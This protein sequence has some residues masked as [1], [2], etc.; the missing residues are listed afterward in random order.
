MI[1]SIINTN[2]YQSKI[3]QSESRGRNIEESLSTGKRYKDSGSIPGYKAVE[4]RDIVTNLSQ[5]DSELISMKKVLSSLSTCDQKIQ[6]LFNRTAEFKS[7]IPKMTG[8][9]ALKSK[10]FLADLKNIINTQNPDG[11]YLFGGNGAPIKSKDLLNEAVLDDKGNRI[12][13]VFDGSTASIDID[14]QTCEMANI[15]EVVNELVSAVHYHGGRYSD[16]SGWKNIPDLDLEANIKDSKRIQDALDKLNESC[17]RKIVET[18]E[19][20]ETRI[21]QLEER[22][23]LSGQRY[24]T[25]T[26]LDEDQK[27]RLAMEL[28]HGLQ[29]INFL[30]QLHLSFQKSLLDRLTMNSARN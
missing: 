4:I 22:C 13:D 10:N 19:K 2:P 29:F 16:D 27:I 24:L 30:M 3:K 5:A 7:Q 18:K 11:G 8:P 21:N 17:L 12:L 28:Q 15:K 9:D 23:D 20:V 6:E 14:G 1:M 26:E 25:E